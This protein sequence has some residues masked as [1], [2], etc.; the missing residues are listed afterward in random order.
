MVEHLYGFGT[1][2][3]GKEE[4]EHRGSFTATKWF[5]VAHIPILPLGSFY[6]RPLQDSAGTVYRSLSPIVERVAWQKRHILNVYALFASAFIAAATIARSSTQPLAAIPSGVSKGEAAPPSI[7]P[8][9]YTTRTEAQNGKPFP[10]TSGYIEDYVLLSDNGY[11]MFTVDNGQS[12][13][14]LYLKL[15][16]PDQ[17][18]PARVFFVKAGDSFTLENLETGDYELRYQDLEMGGIVKTEPLSIRGGETEDDPYFTHTGI[19]IGKFINGNIETQPI[20]EE[21]F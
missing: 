6:V 18:L 7:Q 21:N 1:K 4:G 14:D 19:K 2:F 8:P 15:Y 20:S 3:Y 10:E 11:G 16:A 12:T 13:S 17:I 5:V 9:L